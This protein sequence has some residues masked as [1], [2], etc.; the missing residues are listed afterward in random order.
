MEFKR[1]KS[2]NPVWGYF[3]RSRNG[4]RAKCEICEN[5]ISCKGRSTGAMRNHLCLKHKILLDTKKAKQQVSLENANKSSTGTSTIENYFKPTKESLE[6]IVT[7]LAAVDRISFNTIST[8]K[9]LRQA[10]KTTKT[11]K[12]IQATTNGAKCQKYYHIFFPNTEKRY[13][14]NH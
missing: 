7:E 12:R 11:S 9:Q 8:S 14:E 6:R 1:F 3:L 13:K 10:T 4:D 5:T 2:E